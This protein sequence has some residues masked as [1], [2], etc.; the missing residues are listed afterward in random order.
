MARKASAVETDTPA[1]TTGGG[2]SSE[3]TEVARE[4]ASVYR[5]LNAHIADSEVVRRHSDN[6]CASH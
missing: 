1:H 3:H 2:A 6:Q 5:C 4:G